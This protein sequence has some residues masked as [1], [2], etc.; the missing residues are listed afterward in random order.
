MWPWNAALICFHPVGLHSPWG[1]QGFPRSGG[2]SPKLEL[3]LAAFGNGCVDLYILSL[4]AHHFTLRQMRK[5]QRKSLWLE[6]SWE[7]DRLTFAPLLVKIRF[8]GKDRNI[9][10]MLPWKICICLSLEKVISLS[11]VCVSV[12]IHPDH[13]CLSCAIR[14]I[15]LHLPFPYISH[16]SWKAYFICTHNSWTSSFICYQGIQHI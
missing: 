4:R 11:Y 7:A 12:L 2:D 13:S 15:G 8:I 5:P 14:K 1:K 6:Y 3:L 9:C 16:N 10:V